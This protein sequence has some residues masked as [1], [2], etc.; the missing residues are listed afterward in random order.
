MN[1]GKVVVPLSGIIIDETPS[2]VILVTIRIV[3]FRAIVDVAVTRELLLDLAT[4]VMDPGVVELSTVITPV[5][6]LTFTPIIGELRLQ[7]TLSPCI[8]LPV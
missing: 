3:G 6:G 8:T 5:V 1:A 2:I 4:R 7:V